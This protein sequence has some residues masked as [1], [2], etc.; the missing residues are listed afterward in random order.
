MSPATS[1]ICTGVRMRL[2]RSAST[3][4]LTD[5]I[6]MITADDTA[7]PHQVISIALACAG[8]TDCNR[9]RGAVQRSRGLIDVVR[10]IR[11]LAFV[12]PGSRRPPP[13]PD[14][15]AG[16]PQASP[17]PWLGDEPIHPAIDGV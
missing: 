9:F 7:L 1:S 16:Q 6:V 14:P 4:L 8:N 15:P 10:C 13:P 11:S 3:R 17:K 12:Q 5:A 2:A